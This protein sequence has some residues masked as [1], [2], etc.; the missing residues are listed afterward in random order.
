MPSSAFP[1][2]LPQQKGREAS[3]G[4]Q[5]LA[6]QDCLSQE[7]EFPCLASSD[8]GVWKSLPALS[9]EA[10]LTG[11]RPDPQRL[12]LCQRVGVAPTCLGY[13]AQDP[14][15]SVIGLLFLNL[16]GHRCR[17][18]GIQPPNTPE[19][20]QKRP[21]GMCV[22]DSQGPGCATV[23]LASGRARA[24]SCRRQICA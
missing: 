11:A 2:P 21:P 20:K 5:Q 16:A 12:A 15:A 9:F 4:K 7:P 14:G 24:A 6:L 17:R 19:S 13:K 8:W 1:P 18:G 22:P 10:N 3:A 23:R